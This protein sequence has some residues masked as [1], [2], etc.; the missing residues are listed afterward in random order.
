[1]HSMPGA[2]TTTHPTYAETTHPHYCDRTQCVH[3]GPTVHHRS[4]PELFLPRQSDTTDAAMVWFSVERL[5]EVDETTGTQVEHPAEL[6]LDYGNGQRRR[7]GIDDL[8]EITDRVFGTYDPGVERQL[9][10]S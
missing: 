7:W 10:V 8:R 6:V 5:D 2:D 1:V 9:V 3:L 4:A